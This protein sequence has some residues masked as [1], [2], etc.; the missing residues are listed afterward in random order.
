[1]NAA[2]PQT[3]RPLPSVGAPA[4]DFT[5]PDQDGTERTLAEYRG[6]WVLLYIYPKDDTPGCTTQAC[7]LR[8]VFA[9]LK[10]KQCVVLGLSKDT[11]RSH[12]K[13]VEK[14]GLPFTLLADPKR[15]TIDAYGAQGW[16]TFMGKEY[17]GV[18]RCS[19]L[20]DP[21]GRSATV[22]PQVKPEEHA[23]KILDDLATLQR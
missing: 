6:S 21:Q 5:L 22:Y 11:V 18:L 9:E 12:K 2:S 1:M 23:K 4:P 16:K 14:Y 10:K 8:D 7:G 13:F 3:L 17:L 20:I 15:T 19:F